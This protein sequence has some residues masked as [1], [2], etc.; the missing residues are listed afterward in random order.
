[1]KNQGG[2]IP[3]ALKYLKYYVTIILRDSSCSTKFRTFHRKIYSIIYYFSKPGLKRNLIFKIKTW[4]IKNVFE[5]LLP[6]KL[7]INKY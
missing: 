5:Q 7:I 3:I 2:P 4:K 6:L 1:M